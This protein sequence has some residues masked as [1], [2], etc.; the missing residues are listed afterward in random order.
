[1]CEETAR[2]RSDSKGVSLPHQLNK[3]K[4]KQDKFSWLKRVTGSNLTEQK[5]D[6]MFINLETIWHILFT[7]DNQNLAKYYRHQQT[8]NNQSEISAEQ[9]S[10]L[11]LESM[12]L[13]AIFK[14]LNQDLHLEKARTMN[15]LLKFTDDDDVQ[16]EG[17]KQDIDENLLWLIN[18]YMRLSLLPS[19]SE[20]E[21]KRMLSILELAQID[22]QLD[23]WIGCI[24]TALIEKLDKK[25]DK[26]LGFPELEYMANQTEQ[27]CNLN[28]KALDFK[29]SFENLRDIINN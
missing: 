29:K 5:L 10:K 7:E 28:L 2:S 18:E 12:V 1:M 20:T 4:E 16:K 26:K 8:K 11:E 9:L 24:D 27:L 22:S 15:I 13:L 14:C 23:K 25:L 19:L 21:T 6:K 3:F 17:E